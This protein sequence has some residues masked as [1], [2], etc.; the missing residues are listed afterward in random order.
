MEAPLSLCLYLEASK[1]PGFQILNPIQVF[2]RPVKL[3]LKPRQKVMQ[4]VV[5]DLQ[6]QRQMGQVVAPLVAGDKVYC[7]VYSYPKSMEVAATLW[8]TQERAIVHLLEKYAVDAMNILFDKRYWCDFLYYM[9]TYRM[10]EHEPYNRRSLYKSVGLA[11]DGSFLVSLDLEVDHNTTSIE[12]VEA[13]LAH[14]EKYPTFATLELQDKLLLYPL[15][16]QILSWHKY[17]AESD[18]DPTFFGANL[19]RL[20]VQLEVVEFTVRAASDLM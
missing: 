17:Q 12:K 4:F 16:A 2:D 3:H 1:E 15:V 11:T 8:S 20:H 14:P 9:R 5:E 10:V 13:L 7:V 19:E 6:Q 18:E